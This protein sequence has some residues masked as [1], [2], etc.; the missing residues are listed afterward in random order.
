[1][2]LRIDEIPSLNAQLEEVTRQMASQVPPEALQMLGEFMKDLKESGMVA[3]AVSIGSAIPHFE[4]P[5]ATGEY[6]SSMELLAKGPMVI[7]FYRGAWCPYCNL[8]LQNLQMIL[9]EIHDR[10]AELVAISPQ[11][12]DNSLSLQEKHGLE[13]QVLSDAGN[14]VARKFGLVY[15]L[16]EPMKQFFSVV[17]FDLPGFNGDQSWELPI[18][19]TYVVD[20][21]GIVIAHIDTDWTR[22][23]E[24]RQILDALRDLS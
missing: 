21:E 11:T 17:G 19:A 9:P 8:E 10:G 6:V 23:M 24:P 3:D 5:N 7:A 20:Q 2:S 16:S 14:A 15:S 1:M 12:P 22:R 18:P 4:L 13:F